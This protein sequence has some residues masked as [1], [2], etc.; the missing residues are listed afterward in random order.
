MIKLF[1]NRNIYGSLNLLDDLL[2]E[3]NNDLNVLVK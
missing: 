2:V 3:D 1:L